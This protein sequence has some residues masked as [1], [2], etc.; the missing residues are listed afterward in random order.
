MR[1]IDGAR[2]ASSFASSLAAFWTQSS[3]RLFSASFAVTNRC[4]LRCSYCNFP[5]LDPRDLPLESV[6]RIFGRLRSLG[7]ARLGLVGGEPLLRRDLSDI[8]R[9]ARARRFFVSVNTNL[10]RY[11]RFASTLGQADLVFTSLDGSKVAHRRS[12]GLRS[13]D[14]VLEAVG[15]L[16]SRGVPVIAICVITDP[17]PR[18]ADALLETAD[19]IG[20]QMHFQPRCVDA[21]IVREPE[22]P[23]ENARMRALFAELAERKKSGAPIASSSGYLGYLSRWPDFGVPAVHDPGER[24][25]AGRGFLFVD[26]QGRAYPCAYTKGKVEGFDLL[27]DDW[28]ESLPMQTPCTKCSVGPY[29]EFNRLFRQPL[30]SG[31]DVLRSYT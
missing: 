7:V 8:V 5:F 15:D 24:C 3:P 18:E 20:F 30:R 2:L 27:S 31:L 6:D 28:R 11:D 26:P 9:L 12:R 10:L 22:A 23:A 25:A 1:W 13:Y 14:G 17:D 4:N 19:R 16:V 21:E 29:V